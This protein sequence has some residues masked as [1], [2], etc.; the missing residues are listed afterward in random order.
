MLKAFFV[1]LTENKSKICNQMKL[2]MSLIS[3]R[4]R[5]QHDDHHMT[6]RTARKKETRSN[7]FKIGSEQTQMM[8]WLKTQTKYEDI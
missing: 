2:I 1:Y 6:C 7:Y 4:T 8:I 3:I 5:S